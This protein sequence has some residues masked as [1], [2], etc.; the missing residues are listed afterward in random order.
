MKIGVN[1][2]I[3]R[4][5]RMLMKTKIAW[6]MMTIAFHVGLQFYKMSAW[7]AMRTSMYATYQWVIRIIAWLWNQ[8][9]LIWISRDGGIVIIREENLCPGDEFGISS[10]RSSYCHR[11]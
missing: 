10:S 3:A 11:K 6:L 1:G 8:T 5:V 7:R 9:Y 4:G 2:A